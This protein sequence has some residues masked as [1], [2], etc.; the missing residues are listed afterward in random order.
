MVYY[1]KTKLMT[2][3]GSIVIFLMILNSST[4]Y[5]YYFENI[6]N[7]CLI[8]G[9]G[10]C[11]FLLLLD[12]RIGSL[13]TL[14]LSIIWIISISVPSLFSEITSSLFFYILKFY[15]M[16][17]CISILYYNKVN[18]LNILY[19]ISKI[20]LIWALIN[21]LISIFDIS[22]LPVTNSYTTWWGGSYD[23]Y[24]F[25]FFKN[26]QQTFSIFNLNLQRLHSP[27]SEPG[28]AQFVFN[29]GLFYSLFYEKNRKNKIIWILMFSATA[30]LTTSLTGIAILFILLLIY[31][32]KEK[33]VIA[34]S[35]S[36]LISLIVIYFFISQKLN[37]VSYDDRISDFIFI[38]N[39]AKNK[40]P[41]GIGIGN[42]DYA[43][44][45]IDVITGEIISGGFFSGLF[46]PL[47]YFGFLSLF[48]YYLLYLSIKYF[49]KNKYI[50]L[51]FSV[52]ILIT[53]L[54]EPLT[55]TTLIAVF[56]VHGMIN[57]SQL[58]YIQNT[59]KEIYE[60][61]TNEDLIN[62]SVL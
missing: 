8:L 35:F 62:N 57:S 54:T 26:T 55:F 32:L 45:R 24:L 3:I 59:N 28:V 13:K 30:F 1:N 44:T 23:L 19:K 20:F 29:Y 5:S 16:F 53:L 17:L 27:F 46:T 42:S 36:I 22:I 31:M 40:L 51:A 33:K 7:I 48:F 14:L 60:V 61:K 18:Y 4:I 21:Y 37:S 52:L 49:D 38:F 43:G 11:L 6:S 39:S 25:T 41:F 58:N 9:G 50:N 47:V 2:I 56:L 34:F 10:L 15:V 12:Q